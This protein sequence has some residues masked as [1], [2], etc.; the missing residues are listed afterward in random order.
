MVQYPITK[1]CC[2]EVCKLK[3]GLESEWVTRANPH[4]FINKISNFLGSH[5]HPNFTPLYPIICQG[6]CFFL[7]VLQ[8]IDPLRLQVKCWE[9]HC[10]PNVHCSTQFRASFL[11]TKLLSFWFCTLLRP[12]WVSL[13]IFFRKISTPQ[14][15]FYLQAQKLAQYKTD[16]FKSRPKWKWKVERVLRKGKRVVQSRDQTNLNLVH[17]QS[18]SSSLDLC[19]YVSKLL[20]QHYAVFCVV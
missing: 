6:S 5:D 10:N 19:H 1:Q 15:W 20:Q 14:E 18:C 2:F 16:W 3:C 13:N 11:Y 7:F 12:K 17:F 4:F 8:F 9:G